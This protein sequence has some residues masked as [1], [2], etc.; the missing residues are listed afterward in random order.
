MKISLSDLSFKFV[1]SLQKLA[2]KAFFFLI[3][4]YILPN[5]AAQSLP[6][7][8]ENVVAFHSYS[9]IER[10]TAQQFLIRAFHGY[11]DFAHTI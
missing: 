11:R 10:Y 6:S 2:Q 9:M 1:E 5:P 8:D 3:C 4:G 7:L